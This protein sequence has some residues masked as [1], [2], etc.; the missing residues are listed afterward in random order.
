MVKRTAGGRET[1]GSSPLTLTTLLRRHFYSIVFHTFY[2]I[3]F[4]QFET[5]DL[6]QVRALHEEALRATDAFAER[7]N[8]DSDLDDIHAHYINKD[9]DF[10]VGFADCQLVAM[11]AFRKIREGTAEI[12]RMRVKPSFQG[13]GIGG[14]LLV[15]IEDAIRGAGYEKIELDTTIKQVVACALYEKRGYKEVRRETEG[16]PIEVIF[17][18]K[19]LV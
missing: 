7:G 1:G 13:Q 15:T 12:K 14:R 11:G 9:G 8:W 5:T 3:T 17:Y 16:Y 4:R 10:L 19:E 2:E 18:Q 6:D